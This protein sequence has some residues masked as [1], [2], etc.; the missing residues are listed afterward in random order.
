[1]H[2]ISTSFGFYGQSKR[3]SFS[4]NFFRVCDLFPLNPKLNIFEENKPAYQ[5]NLKFCQKNWFFAAKRKECVI[6]YLKT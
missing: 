1:M 5:K 4:C 3:F 2:I 6:E